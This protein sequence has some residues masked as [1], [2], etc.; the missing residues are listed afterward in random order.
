MTVHVFVGPTLHQDEVRATLDGAR[1]FGPVAFGDV[2]RSAK[3]RPQ[4]IAIIDGYFER[5]PAVWHKEILWAMSE[6]VHVFGASSLGALRAAELADF[7]MQ[8]IGAIFEGFRSGSLEDDD[9]VTIAHA[10]PEE[11]FVPLSEA[12]VNVRATV[13]AAVKAGVIAQA[14]GD[15]LLTVTKNRF[16][17]ERSFATT[18]RDAEAHGAAVTELRALRAWLPDGRVDQKA[19]DAR[20]LL[21]HVRDWLRGKPKQL[22]VSYRLE[23]TDA[24]LEAIRVAE[25]N[26]ETPALH[27]SAFASEEQLEVELKLAGSYAAA[28]DAGAARAAAIDVARRAGFQPDAPALAH[29]AETLRRDL[30]LLQADDFEAWRKRER[31]DDSSLVQLFEDQARMLWGQPQTEASAR[32]YVAD[33]LRVAA[34]Y[35]P[36]VERAEAKARAVADFGPRGPSLRDLRMD[37]PTLWSWFFETVLGRPIPVGLYEFARSI[38][39]A[40]TDELRSAVLNELYFQRTK[41]V[42]ET[43]A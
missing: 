7:G 21:R 5:V 36:L 11:G 20:L 40:D 38:G 23:P 33:A 10:A 39:F 6:G 13:V 15:V 8:G 34:R 16:Y 32:G 22:R 3:S 14:T 17:A 1:V 19:A 12:M 29:A 28:L 27:G 26:A 35:G 43:K 18:I 30:G 9:E 24:W 2:Y 41:R 4:A 42:L 31:I 37:E 25:R